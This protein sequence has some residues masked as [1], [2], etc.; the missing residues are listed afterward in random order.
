[1]TAT[2]SKPTTD[3]TG[4][5]VSDLAEDTPDQPEQLEVE[6]PTPPMQIALPGDWDTLDGAFGGNP[7]DSSEIRLLGGRMPIQGSFAKGAEFDI[8]VRVKVTG[9]LGQDFT[10]DWGTVQRTVR[11]HMARMLSVRRAS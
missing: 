2:A 8:V 10:D 7:P 6:K 5:E 3:K 1:M 4:V 9:V 11:R